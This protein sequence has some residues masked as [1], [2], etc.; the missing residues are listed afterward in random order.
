M[1]DGVGQL[2]RQARLQLMHLVMEEEVKSL[3]GGRHQQHDGRKAHRW[4]SEAG[5]CVVDGQKVPIRR[6]RLRTASDDGAKR[7]QRLGCYEL[8]QR[9][10]LMMRGL[11]TRNYGAVVKDFHNAYGIENRR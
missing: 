7:E 11:S 1:Q 2:V 9:S 6:A 5:Y 10:G 8:F 3:A 4:A